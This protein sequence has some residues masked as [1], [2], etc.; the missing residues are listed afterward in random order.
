MR[1]LFLTGDAGKND[2][3]MQDEN[4]NI[5]YY[6]NKFTA[7]N[8]KVQNSQLAAVLVVHKIFDKATGRSELKIRV[9]EIDIGE[10]E[11]A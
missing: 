11:L 1:I 6:I 9:S 3:F 4:Q 10:L 5:E 7:A 8:E 2:C